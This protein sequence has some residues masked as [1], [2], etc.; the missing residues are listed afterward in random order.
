MATIGRVPRERNQ[1]AAR[2]PERPNV[3]ESESFSVR[4]AASLRSY[5]DN[6]GEQSRRRAYGLGQRALEDGLGV[7]E[8]AAAHDDALRSLLRAG[9]ADPMIAAAGEFF[10]ECLSPFEM[11]HRGAR[12]GAHAWQHLNDTLEKEAKRIAHALHDQAGQLLASVYLA[13]ADLPP[14]LP[15]QERSRVEKVNWLL[16]RMESELRNLSHELRPTVLDRLGLRPALQFLAENVARRAG[17][18]V[19]IEG[20]DPGRLPPVVEITL[21]RI[22]Q[23]AL[24]NVVRHAAASG[25]SIELEIDAR[26]IACTV[27]DN[28]AGFSIE[29]PQGASGLGLLLMRERLNALGGSLRLRSA[30]GCGTTLRAEVPQGG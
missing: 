1:A 21:Y 10:A 5:L 3:C 8:L 9:A 22:A 11:S 27:R 20:K 25:V 28:G 15:P 7:L 19:R 4:Y 12:A 14:H 2:L 24:N 6:P 30:P 13:L 26:R 16:R 17:I 23:E 18:L 29:T